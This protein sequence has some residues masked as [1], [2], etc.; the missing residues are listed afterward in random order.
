[1]GVAVNDRQISD[2]DTVSLTLVTRHFNSIVPENCM[3]CENIHPEE[4]RYYFA[5]ADSFVNFGIAHDMAIIGHC[6]IWHSQCAPWFFVDK[7]GNQIS[8]EILKRRMK[9]HIYTVVGRYK[10]LIHGWD[11]VNEA[12][13]ENGEYRKS[14]FYEILGEDYIPL[15]FQYAHEADPD[16]ELYYNDY[17]MNFP[18]HRAAVVSLVRSLKE[19]GLRIDAVGMQGHMGMNYP[20][21]RQFEKSIVAFGDAGVNVMITEWDMSALPTIS[22][23]ANVSDI[24][25]YNK[26]MNP[27]PDGLPEKVSRKWNKRMKMFFNLFLKHSDVISRVTAWGVSDDVSWRNDYPMHGR[28]DYPLFFDRNLQPKPFVIELCTENNQ[29]QYIK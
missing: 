23:S 26:K 17:G 16:A 7:D 5:A 12:F 19:K 28:M 2:P 6:L 4:D 21:V 22:Q 20:N 24:V 27:Y 3:K 10:G 1:I 13:L 11:V 8:A 14:K 9:E 18:K 15:A 25:K 29:K